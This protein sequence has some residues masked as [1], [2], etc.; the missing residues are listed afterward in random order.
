MQEAVTAQRDVLR[1][2]AA[3]VG[4]PL[5]VEIVRAAIAT[6]LNGLLRGHSGIRPLVLERVAAILN[7]GLAPVVPRT[8]S[9]GASGDLAPSA[10]A[11]LPLVGEG[12]AR[13]RDRRGAPGVRGARRRRPRARSSS[14]RRRRSRSSTAPISWRRSARSR[15]CGPSG[16]SIP[17]M[18]RPPSRSRRSGGRPRPSMPACTS[19][20]RFRASAARRPSCGP[21]SPGR[22]GSAPA[23]RM[24][25]TP[26]RSGACP[27]S[28]APHGRA[29]A[30]AARLVEAD[31]NAVTDNPLVFDEPLEVVS[32]GNF[33]GQALA[34]GLDTLRIAVTD[35][36]AISERRTF[37]LLSPSLNAGLP[38]FLTPEAGRL[39][40]LH[41]RAVHGRCPRRRAARRSP[42][43]S[44][45]TA[46]RPRTT[47]RTT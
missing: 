27:R 22:S 38:A 13:G 23:R 25:R 11:F 16:S 37:R 32:A 29:L 21:S 41:G 30:F 6:R 4:D 19:C 45:S 33:H 12:V 35:V 3:G 31:L 1:S 14:R 40:R 42:I 24:C 17:R 34:L 2:H 20:A 26:T 7:A 5:P 46:C 18:P 43:P 47:R 28:T 15:R 36:A 9:L 10:H 8:G 39:E 44:A